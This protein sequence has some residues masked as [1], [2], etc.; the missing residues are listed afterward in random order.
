MSVDIHTKMALRGTQLTICNEQT[1]GNNSEL[2]DELNNVKH[3]DH[4][5]FNDIRRFVAIVVHTA[6]K[7]GNAALMHRYG[8][9]GIR[10]DGKLYVR[11]WKTTPIAT[12]YLVVDDINFFVIG[13]L[14]F[15]KT[16]NDRDP[17]KMMKNEEASSKMIK[18]MIKNEEAS[19]T[20]DGVST[21]E[22]FKTYP[23][24]LY[25]TEE[26]FR[27]LS[28]DEQSEIIEKQSKESDEFL[29][30][31]REQT[32]LE[33]QKSESGRQASDRQIK[34]EE[35]RA[36]SRQQFEMG[37]EKRRVLAQ[38]GSE[39]G[40]QESDSEV[41]YRRHVELAIE[42]TRMLRLTREDRKELSRFERSEHDYMREGKNFYNGFEFMPYEPIEPQEVPGGD[43]G[44]QGY[45]EYYQHLLNHH[46]Q[47]PT[48][49]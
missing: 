47:P 33:E 10:R 3:D 19:L 40:H 1:V 4:V 20:S 24:P 38:Q 11:N 9:C 31:R 5:H 25:P 46:G 42:E 15:M 12:W 44:G 2:C 48:S 27:M 23:P 7:D 14:S 6:P 22:L 26:Q 28:M 49:P 29:E 21:F 18:M 39:S 13:P 41:E 35:L 45:F 8:L 32:A 36:L 34:Y 43:T 17:I 16:I 30:K 37:R